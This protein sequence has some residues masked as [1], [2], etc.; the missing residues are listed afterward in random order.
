MSSSRSKSGYK[1]LPSDHHTSAEGVEDPVSEED[2]WSNALPQPHVHEKHSSRGNVS[3]NSLR[4]VE[5]SS[6]R[7]S[8]EANEPLLSD[9]EDDG[10]LVG[11][12]KTSDDGH[13]EEEKS[14]SKAEYTIAFS[15]FVV[16]GI[17]NLQFLTLVDYYF[18]EYFRTRPGTIG[19]FLLVPQLLQYALESHF[20]L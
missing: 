19:F 2:T 7:P 5:M 17:H 3:S 18:R 12:E 4:E 11:E 20:H 9:P 8:M 13:Q 14:F 15:H 10:T 1:P 6:P 16:S